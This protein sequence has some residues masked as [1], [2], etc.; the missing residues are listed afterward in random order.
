M[1][2]EFNKIYLTIVV[3]HLLANLFAWTLLVAMTKPVILLALIFHFN[4]STRN[5]K[6]SFRKFIF[7]GLFFSLAGDIA[8]LFVAQ[9]EIFFLIGLGLFLFAHTSYILAFIVENNSEKKSY[10]SLKKLF[11]SLPYLLI[12]ITSLYF[13]HDRLG[14]FQ[15]P[16]LIYMGVITL[17]GIFTA[18][19]HTLV[20]K[21]SFLWILCGALSFILS[22]LI[23]AIN[24]FHTI[25]P[26]AGF[27]IMMTYSLAQYLIVE[28]SLIAMRAGLK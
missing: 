27:F 14:E 22:D 28:G 18:W 26:Q 9:Q 2:R 3:F 13:L 10:L 8:L 19:R 25:I 11:V 12:A 15:L 23:L 21:Q 7:F 17:M 4:S 6:S 16:V 20:P 1:N 5:Q 24:R